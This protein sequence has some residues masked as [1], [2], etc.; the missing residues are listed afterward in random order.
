MFSGDSER[1]WGLGGTTKRQ[2]GQ[3]WAGLGWRLWAG[4]AELFCGRRHGR[5]G[6]LCGAA[7]AAKNLRLGRLSRARSGAKKSVAGPPQA[8]KNSVAGAPQA[9]GQAGKI[10]C[11]RAAGAEKFGLWLARSRPRSV[12]VALALRLGGSGSG[13]GARGAGSWLGR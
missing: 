9:A 7:G 6:R 13:S 4:L 8:P 10:S 1:F 11:W 5:S 3:A 12:A 2:P